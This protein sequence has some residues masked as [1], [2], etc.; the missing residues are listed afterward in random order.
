MN[1]KS[2]KAKTTASETKKRGRKPASSPALSP[3]QMQEMFEKFLQQQA[4]GSTSA[5]KAKPKPKQLPEHVSGFKNTYVC[6]LPLDTEG[7]YFFSFGLKKAEA[8][9]EHL[10]AIEAFVEFMHES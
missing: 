7:K 6:K 5:P 9:L 10:K 1:L 2:A 4:N 8:I 3:E